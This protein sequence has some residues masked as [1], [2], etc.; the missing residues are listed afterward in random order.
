MRLINRVRRKYSS[1]FKHHAKQA[2]RRAGLFPAARAIYRSLNG[3]IRTQRSKEIAFY[4]ELLPHNSL[5]FDI[6]ANLGQKAEV[7]LACGA[8]VIVVEPNS[9]CLPTL[10]FHF[11]KN[12][13]A[14]IVPQAVGS[15]VGMIDLHVHG[16]DSTASV[17]ENWD[18]AVFGPGRTTAVLTVPVITLDALIERFGAPHFIKIDVEGFEVEVLRGLSRPVP[19]LSFEYHS[20][21]DRLRRCL[22]ETTK[23]GKIVIRASDMNCNWVTAKTDNIEE[24]LNDIKADKSRTPWL[25]NGDMFVW[26]EM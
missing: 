22:I 15:A 1:M 17:N 6:G 9:F 18:R 3:S 13:R 26:P 7:F 10:K 12:Q 2:L 23:F 19:L 16:T 11:A 25:M 24:C 8:R 21:I 14:V 20:D 5:C 4:R